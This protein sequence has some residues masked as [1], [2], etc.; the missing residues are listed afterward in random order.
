MGVDLLFVNGIPFL[1][2]ISCHLYFTTVEAVINVEAKTLL[3]S[4]KGAFSNYHKRR[5]KIQVVMADNQF[6]FLTD[7]LAEMQIQMTPLA[8]GEHEKYIS[9][10]IN[11]A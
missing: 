3:K 1:I 2:A 6:D 5:F 4:L 9:V 8:K 11:D 10:I 7:A